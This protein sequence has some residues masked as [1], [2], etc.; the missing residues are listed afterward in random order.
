MYPLFKDTC[1]VRIISISSSLKKAE[2]FS[3]PLLLIFFH[4]KTPSNPSMSARRESTLTRVLSP[5]PSAQPS[6]TRPSTHYS[7]SSRG[8]SRNE[9]FEFLLFSYLL[10]F[11]HH[12]G[13]TGEF[14]RAGLLFLFD[15]AFLPSQDLDVG[16]IRGK[17]DGD[18]LQDA[19][20]ALGEYILD[21]DFA[22]VMAAAVGAVYSL[23]PS[24]VRVPTL[25]EQT[26]VVNG[27]EQ[28]ISEGATLASGGRY[29]GGG[30]REA[31]VDGE[32]L[33]STA[34]PDIRSQ[35]DLLLKLFAFLQDI[36][37]RCSPSVLSSPSH[38]TIM[39]THL[40]GAAMSDSTLDAIQTS[41]LDNILYPSILE[42]SA[43]DGT[44]VAVMTYLHVI[45]SNIDDG[46][47][48]TRLLHFLLDTD[49]DEGPR[50]APHHQPKRGSKSFTPCSTSSDQQ[51][52][53]R[54]EYFLSLIH[55]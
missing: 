35:L 19:Q 10:R 17:D 40:L 54:H 42:S 12:E 31:E 3:P 38:T 26:G 6:L 33:P 16:S 8:G 11:V 49:S 24:K 43:Q 36:I 47:L 25:S 46:P 44:S 28:R 5:T 9:R 22:E 52:G 53:E 2:H 29:L 21:G 1:L 34:D 39:N 48:P 32:K 7:H 30:T 27:E 13:R 55:I 18:A 20:D 51:G 4:D 50:L 15:I 23:L 37:T 41:L 14:A 45:L